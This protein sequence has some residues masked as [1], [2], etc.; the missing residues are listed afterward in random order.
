MI[1]NSIAQ[2]TLKILAESLDDL[3]GQR[4]A[5]DNRIRSLRQVYGYT[6]DEDDT[7]EMARLQAI[8]DGITQLEAM[9]TLDLKRALRAHP[10][11]SWVKATAGIG[12]KTGARLLAAIGDPSWNTLHGRPRTVSELW[13]FCGYHVIDGAA[14][15][16]RKGEKANWSNDAKMRAFL[17]AEA[18]IKVGVRKTDDADDSDGYDLAHRQA[19]TRY[20]QVYLDGRA[21]Y[22]G[23]VHPTPCHRCTAAGQPPAEVGTPRSAAH[24]HAM[25]VRL[26]AKEILRDL[27]G[28][29]TALG[30]GHPRHDAPTGTAGA[31]AVAS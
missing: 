4:K 29:A 25:A 21:K 10:L 26:V 31:M 20:G 27:W 28:E 23:S 2:D 16:R 3:E 11:G 13:A 8:A 17:C 14:A 1:Y 24:Q 9:A 7:P 30:A 5:T 22:A 19:L 15:R 12:E 6:D 18:A